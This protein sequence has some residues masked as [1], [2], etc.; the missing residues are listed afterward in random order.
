MTGNKTIQHIKIL[1]GIA[2]S[3]GVLIL[4]WKLPDM[5]ESTQSSRLLTVV[6]PCDLKQSDCKAKYDKKSISLNVSPSFIP[7]MAPLTFTVVLDNIQAKT[8]ILELK[9]KEMFMGI[10]KVQL[11]PLPDG[12]TWKGTTE[13][14][15]CVTGSM[16][17]LASVLTY[18]DST[19]EPHKATFEFE[20]P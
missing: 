3:L 20:S 6:E 4:L 5:L 18:T 7:S 16:V 11:S 9:G 8:V 19:T 17:W 1:T 13:L 10:N 2:C 15:V 12:I 14:A